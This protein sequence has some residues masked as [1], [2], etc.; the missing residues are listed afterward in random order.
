MY[1]P[2]VFGAGSARDYLGALLGFMMVLAHWRSWRLCSV[3]G[4]GLVG[5]C[6]LCLG[7]CH[8]LVWHWKRGSPCLGHGQLA[9]PFSSVHLVGPE[10][11]ERERVISEMLGDL[12]VQLGRLRF[13]GRQ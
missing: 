11:L 3:F 7:W 9:G 4:C 8:C 13:L 5:C 10:L 12:L 6:F 1:T 2:I